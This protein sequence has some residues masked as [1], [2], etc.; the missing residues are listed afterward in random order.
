MHINN[1]A[2]PPLSGLGER[3]GK[4]EMTAMWE[5]TGGRREKDGVAILQKL[6]WSWV[7]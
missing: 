4:V 6:F 1:F 5:G 3:E 7:K 2:Y